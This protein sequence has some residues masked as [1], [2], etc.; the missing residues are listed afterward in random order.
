[1]A[2]Q[3]TKKKAHLLFVFPHRQMAEHALRVLVA[4]GVEEPRI[5][6]FA[7]ASA[8]PRVTDEELDH[9]SD[10]GG[11]AGGGIGAIAGAAICA[12]PGIGPVLGVG[13]LAAA[14]TGAITGVTVGGVSGSILGA[15]VCEGVAALARHHLR[16]GKAILLIE[17]DGDEAAIFRIAHEEGASE[18]TVL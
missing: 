1:M 2:G 18:E 15:G 17:N 13:P 11:A 7:C 14:I 16:H 4:S 12:I 3:K 8:C 10:V 6:L 5:T 9:A